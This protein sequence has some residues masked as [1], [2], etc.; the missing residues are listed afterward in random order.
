M[1][2]Y[3]GLGCKC[4]GGFVGNVLSGAVWGCGKGGGLGKMR[5]KLVDNSLPFGVV[6]K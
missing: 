3:M 6:E 5:N 1:R 2:L 4:F